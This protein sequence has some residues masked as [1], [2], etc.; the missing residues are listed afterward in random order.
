MQIVRVVGARIASLV[1]PGDVDGRERVARPFVQDQLGGAPQVFEVARSRIREN[2]DVFRGGRPPTQ[3]PNS[4]EFGYSPSKSTTSKPQ[5]RIGLVQFL[6][7]PT[8]QAVGTVI[9][10]VEPADILHPQPQEGVGR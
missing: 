2:S 8:A 6:A 7:V 5:V 4:H 10:V 9:P 1:D 3:S